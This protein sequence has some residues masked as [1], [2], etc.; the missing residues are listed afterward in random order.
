ML[1]QRLIK[2]L[3]S[4]NL[5]I[6]GARGTGKSTLLQQRFPAS[7]VKRLDL[8]EAET[9]IRLTQNPDELRNIV[10]ALPD[11]ITHVIIDE[12]Q[13]IPKLLDIVHL[14]IEELKFKEKKIFFVL[15]GSSARKLKKGGA[16]LLAGRAFEYHLFPFSSLELADKFNLSEAL[17]YGMLPKIHGLSN[18]KEEK[19]KFL[20]TYTHTYL[21][22]EIIAEQ[23]IRNLEPFRRF[24]EVSAQ[25]N[26]K[27]INYS[28]ISLD[29]GTSEVTVKQY[30][31][32]LEDTLIG[33]F[34]EP[35]HHSF[36]KRLSSKPK[37]YYFDIGVAR[38]LA[39][40][41]STPVLPGTSYYGEVFEH[42]VI[43]ECWKL[44]KY[45]NPEYRF[46]YLKTKD[47]AEVDLVIDRPGQKHLFIE[48]KSTDNVRK[49]QLSSFQ[50]IVSD[51][52]EHGGE[53]ESV[54]FSRDP[55]AKQ[56]DKVLVLP[57]QEGVKKFFMP[58]IEEITMNAA[59][60]VVTY[61]LSASHKMAATFLDNYIKLDPKNLGR[62]GSSVVLLLSFSLEQIFKAILFTNNPGGIKKIHTISEL[63]EQLTSENQQSLCLIY[64]ANTGVALSSDELKNMLKTKMD[65]MFVD[66]RYIYESEGNIGKTFDLQSVS[67][68]IEAAQALFKKIK[69]IE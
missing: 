61:E 15:T 23:V 58:K 50:R 34:L 22:Q 48:I 4:Q 43:L 5:L 65:N 24:L 68:V 36:R 16:N 63:Y 7:S 37:F 39:R 6:F 51:F 11:K 26:G 30:F 40:L 13:K 12:I 21:Q 10:H 3:E 49:E 8:L 53:C 35:F 14:L 20:T 18:S 47:D 67:K 60:D 62:M 41:L 52:N 19:E 42:H 66:S 31:G 33:F 29:V 2:L 54:C 45:F 9:E 25:C 69:G 55:H 57:W 32:I 64:A 56:L 17:N 44:A 1:I 38:A 46:S 28:K 27:I 59:T